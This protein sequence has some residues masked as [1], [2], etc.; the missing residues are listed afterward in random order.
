MAQHRAEPAV[1]AADVSTTEDYRIE[2]K[3]VGGWH[4]CE[5]HHDPHVARQALVFYREKWPQYAWRVLK[6]R[7]TTEAEVIRTS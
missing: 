2:W 7:T 3:G 1:P 5:L 4:H 6:V